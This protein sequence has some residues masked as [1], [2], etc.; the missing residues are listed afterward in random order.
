[1]IDRA[2]SLRVNADRPRLRSSCAAL[3]K[4]KG[5]DQT[6]AV[7]AWESRFGTKVLSVVYA[8][9]QSLASKK[10]NQKSKA[11]AK[12]YCFSRSTSLKRQR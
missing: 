8:T 9:F 10:G 4:A 3:E 12:V 7:E 11:T 5:K 6:I 2:D 1:M